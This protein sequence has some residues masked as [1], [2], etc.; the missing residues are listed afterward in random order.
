MKAYIP[1]F[2]TK[3]SW[4]GKGLMLFLCPL[5]QSKI[6]GGK[7]IQQGK[8]KQ[9]NDL[10]IVFPLTFPELRAFSLLLLP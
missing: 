10:I 3:A 6:F 5:T 2:K 4:N 1:N 9:G 8:E 7:Y